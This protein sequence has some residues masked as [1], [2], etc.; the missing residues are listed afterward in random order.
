L[1]GDKNRELTVVGSEGTAKLDCLEQKAVLVKDG[2]TVQIPIDF[3]NTLR[4]EILQFVECNIHSKRN[5]T[6]TNPADGIVG[7]Q[8]VRL[9][10][11]A[12]ESMLQDR[13]VEV[14]LPLAEEILAR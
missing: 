3:S 5:E 13:T 1:D 2:S 8:V 12:R 9:L 11:A 14:R 10:E 7:A 6:Y 4:D